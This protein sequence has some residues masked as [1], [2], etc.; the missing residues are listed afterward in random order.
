MLKRRATMKPLPDLQHCMNA[1]AV[2]ETTGLHHDKLTH[3]WK[4]TMF[5]SGKYDG[6]TV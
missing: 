1:G 2:A 4:L 6:S 3:R 5:R